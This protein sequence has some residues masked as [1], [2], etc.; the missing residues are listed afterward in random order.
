MAIQKHLQALH[1][2]AALNRKIQAEH[3]Y[4][5][6]RIG[7]NVEDQIFWEDAAAKA[8]AKAAD[9]E[10]ELLAEMGRQPV[11]VCP[12]CLDADDEDLHELV[13]EDGVG[14]MVVMCLCGKPYIANAKKILVWTT[15]KLPT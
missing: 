15:R 13:N 12:H 11:P 4:R 9:F 5:A 2:N 7:N 8:G 1:E 3:A 6:Q 14:S 10:I